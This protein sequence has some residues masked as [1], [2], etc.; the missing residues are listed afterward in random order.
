MSALRS[1]TRVMTWSPAAKRASPTSI[2]CSPSRPSLAHHLPRQRVQR[3]TSAFR[4]ATISAS[5]PRSKDSPPV[6]RPSPPASPRRRGRPRPAR[7]SGRARAPRAPSPSRMRFAAS[8]SSSWSW[9]ITSSRTIGSRALGERAR[10]AARL[11]LAELLR[12]RRSGRA[13]P[14][15]RS[16]WSI[17]RARVA[18]STIP[19]SSIS[20]TEPGASAA[21]PRALRG[22]ARP[23]RLA[24][25]VASRPSA[26]STLA[27]RQVGAAA[28]S[29]IPAC[30]QPS[31]AATV[32]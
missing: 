19:A 20:R 4:F 16:A 29:S 6:A 30:A 2:S 3:S 9:R 5:S 31:A 28:R 27:A 22:R 1:L 18:E 26:R 24:M 25:L 13:W 8:R 17:R 23:S 32:A 15:P 11:D 14:R 12:G 10:K 21:R 7:R